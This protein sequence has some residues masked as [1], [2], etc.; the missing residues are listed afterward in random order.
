MKNIIIFCCIAS[1]LLSCNK[2]K[3]PDF[4]YRVIGYIYNSIDSTPFENT[5]FKIYNLSHTLSGKKTQETFFTTDSKGY[6]DVT[7]SFGGLLAWPAYFDGAAYTGPPHFGFSGTNYTDET[8]RIY[9]TTM[10]TI[11]TTP[12]H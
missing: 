5:Q 8:N 1:F 2:N 6:F 3:K 12:Y 9:V 7:S 10:D 4:R 11:Y